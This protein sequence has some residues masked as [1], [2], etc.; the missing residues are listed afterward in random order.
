[1]IAPIAIPR[2]PIS[3]AF[4]PMTWRAFAGAAAAASFA[5]APARSIRS[6]AMS[7]AAS[8]PVLNLSVTASA[9]CA[10]RLP[11]IVCRRP[12]RHLAHH[13]PCW[14]PGFEPR[15]LAFTIAP[16]R[17]RA[18]RRVIH[19]FPRLVHRGS[20]RLRGAVA[21][22]L[23]GQG[24]AGANHQERQRKPRARRSTGTATAVPAAIACIGFSM[25]CCFSAL[26]PALGL[27]ADE[28]GDFRFDVLRRNLVADVFGGVGYLL[29]QPIDGGR[30]LRAAPLGLTPQF[31]HGSCHDVTA[32]AFV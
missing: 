10:A 11:D 4:S 13:W 32:C 27:V 26:D 16:K 14:R 30:Q 1:M 19:H 29:P 17:L 2:P 12:Q 3:A 9:A 21:H 8:M 28:I 31:L 25:A 20:R 24:E 22:C 5:A 7:E 6:F 18:L 15:R 23:R